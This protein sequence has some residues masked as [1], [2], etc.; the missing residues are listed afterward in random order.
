M[1][2]RRRASASR[3]WRRGRTKSIDL[4]EAALLI[5]AEAYPGA[6][7]R[8]VPG[9][10]STSLRTDARA[11]GR[12]RAQ[13]R[14]AH[15]SVERS[16]SSSTRAF[17]GNRTSYYDPPQ[18]LPQR[19][20]RAAHRHPD[21]AHARL[22]RGRPPPRAPGARC[23]ISRPLP[24]QA[25]AATRETSSSTRS[26]AGALADA[27]ARNACAPS[28]GAE[29]PARAAPPAPRDGRRRSWC[30]CCATSST[31]VPAGEASSRRPLSY[32]ERILLVDPQ[33][34]TS[35]A[36]AVCSTRSS[37]ATR[38][39]RADLERF[40]EL[41]PDDPSGRDDPRAS[42]S[43]SAAVRRCCTDVSASRSR[44]ASSS[45]GERI[46]ACQRRGRRSPSGQVGVSRRQAR[47]RRI[48]GGVPARA[49]CARS[50]ASR[51][52][53]ARG[54]VGRATA[55]PDAIAG[56]AVFFLVSR[57]ID[58][59]PREPRLRDD[60]L[61]L[62]ARARRA[63]TSSTPI[64]P[65]STDSR[66]ARFVSHQCD[67]RPDGGRRAV[68]A[69]AGPRG[70]NRERGHRFD[71]THPHPRRRW[72]GALQSESHA[73]AGS[74]VVAELATPTVAVRGLC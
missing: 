45:D 33:T 62:A 53:S 63:S 15:R 30:A 24:R 34:R 52:G 31:I 36:I 21:H 61:G 8:R 42:R 32:S 65:W 19:G 40:L 50:S 56:R 72:R 11:A 23:R 67:E 73:T 39:A 68:A 16:S 58:G 2:D 20:P 35:C 48:D 7:H 14:R 17:T 26:S 13:R 47:G 18:Q 27:S 4:A 44:P 12:R 71:L 55:T 5:A 9:A 10:A 69:G 46:L 41:E 66:A 59:D 28:L 38:A 3:S 60:S 6:R 43:R 25:C 37:N 22:H 57:P 51:R 29:A 1:R 74:P 70:R 49:S 64:E 54:V